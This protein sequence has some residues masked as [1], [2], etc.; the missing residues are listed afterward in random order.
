MRAL[1]PPTPPTRLQKLEASASMTLTNALGADGLDLQ[2]RLCAFRVNLFA[3]DT[4]VVSSICLISQEGF[5]SSQPHGFEFLVTQFARHAY[6]II[7]GDRDLGKRQWDDEVV[8]R[9]LATS[10][11][12]PPLRLKKGRTQPMGSAIARRRSCSTR[13]GRICGRSRNSSA[14]RISAP[15]CAILTS[16]TNR[17]GR[18]WRRSVRLWSKKAAAGTDAEVSVRLNLATE[19]RQRFTNRTISCS[20]RSSDDTKVTTNRPRIT[21]VSRELWHPK[22]RQG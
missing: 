5:H 4:R 13:W 17:P 6:G 3:R 2:G 1:G 11:R 21:Y 20:W 15:P 9:V 18:R 22:C 19:R 14:I 7:D 10:N 12:K 8:P 16:A